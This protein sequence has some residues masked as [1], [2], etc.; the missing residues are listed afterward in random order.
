MRNATVKEIL[1]FE[2]IKNKIY[3]TYNHFECTDEY[4]LKEEPEDTKAKTQKQIVYINPL[5]DYLLINGYLNEKFEMI[6]G[7]QGDGLLTRTQQGFV[8]AIA[9][10]KD[11]DPETN[12]VNS[13]DIDNVL[14]VFNYENM[15]SKSFVNYGLL[16]VICSKASLIIEYQDCIDSMVRGALERSDYS[17]L[18]KW[19]EFVEYKKHIINQITNQ[20]PNI[21]STILT[22]PDFE[23]FDKYDFFSAILIHKQ[24]K[25][26]EDQKNIRV[27]LR[28]QPQI[29]DIE[30]ECNKSISEGTLK[31]SGLLPTLEALKN[32]L[33]DSKFT[34]SINNKLT[35]VQIS[36]FLKNDFVMLNIESFKVLNGINENT[37][38]PYCFFHS[39]SDELNIWDNE[40]IDE[41]YQRLINK[42]FDTELSLVIEAIKDKQII[43]D[44]IVDYI[45][46]FKLPKLTPE[47]IEDIVTNHT[48]ELDYITSDFSDDVTKRLLQAGKYKYSKENIV[49]ACQE[50]SEESKAYICN[51][52]IN[53]AKKL[54]NLNSYFGE[55]GDESL[56]HHFE[57]IALEKTIDIILF[58]FLLNTSGYTIYAGEINKKLSDEEC[59]FIIES[60]CLELDS[61]NFEYVNTNNPAAIQYFMSNFRDDLISVT[62]IQEMA[63]EQLMGLLHYD[64][65]EIELMTVLEYGKDELIKEDAIALYKVLSKFDFEYPIPYEVLMAILKSSITQEEKLKIYITN[66]QY[67]DTT[68]LKE[69][70][71]AI[72]KPYTRIAKSNS[73]NYLDAS[74]LNETLIIEL[75]NEKHLIRTIDKTKKL[76]KYRFEWKKG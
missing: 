51:M 8:K 56:F 21:I 15:Q 65:N 45:H 54:D 22:R 13:L 31:N 12:I 3:Q 50:Y 2:G 9:S 66:V 72:G 76:S 6:I 34:T 10:N 74:L 4:K 48:F 44:A 53:I 42:L 18:L 71:A 75:Y 26:K 29:I 33:K 20:A 55:L 7:R 58:K 67:F 19:V 52:P 32:T 5:I 14:K 57:E 63:S 73:Y 36:F 43:M 49:I 39:H 70:L 30:K 17:E 46:L 24:I 35:E 38:L 59:E 64:L 47:N 68:E 23:G 16:K 62:Y 37:P 61:D 69:L 28:R 11:T 41:A 40:G 27:F 25:I 1:Q 60:E